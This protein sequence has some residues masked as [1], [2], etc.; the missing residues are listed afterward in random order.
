MLYAIKI[1][2]EEFDMYSPSDT[3]RMFSYCEKRFGFEG[4][5]WEE[6]KD[7]YGYKELS[8]LLESIGVKFEKFYE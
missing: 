5:Q 3:E 2:N 8:E 4:S 6:I 7:N 1:G